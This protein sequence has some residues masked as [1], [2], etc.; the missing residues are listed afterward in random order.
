MIAFGFLP[1]NLGVGRDLQMILFLLYECNLSGGDNQRWWGH[2]N[3]TCCNKKIEL[4]AL[5]DSE[6]AKTLGVSNHDYCLHSRP[7][8]TP[9][10]TSDLVEFPLPNILYLWRQRVVVVFLQC[11][12]NQ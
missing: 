10:I 4:F 6:D 5:T 7:L 3:T 12:N 9:F 1:Q 2:S 11:S 8:L